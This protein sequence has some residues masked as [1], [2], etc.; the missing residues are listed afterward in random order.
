MF[1]KY[2]VPMPDIGCMSFVYQC[3]VCKTLAA[4]VIK[5]TR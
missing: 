3:M 5:L 4:D 2:K 1:F